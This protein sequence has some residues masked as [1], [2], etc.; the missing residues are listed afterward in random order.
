MGAFLAR[1]LFAS[2]LVMVAVSTL[3]FAL[4][5][6]APGGPSVLADPKLTREEV[7]AIERRLGIDRPLPVQY[8]RWM[9][10]ALRGDLGASFLYRTPVRATIASRL[11]NTALLAG[12]ALLVATLVAV[13]LAL[14]AAEHPGGVADRAAGALSFMALSTPAFWL[15][16]VA[17]LCFA[18]WLR[19]LPAG[20]AATPGLEGSLVDRARHA[21]LP[22]CVLAAGI[23]AEMLRYTRAAAGR[24]Y[25][26][27]W[28]RTARAKGVGEREVR[29]HHVMRHVLVAVLTLIGL[30]LPRLLGG[31]AITETIFAWPGMGR[32]GVEAAL[33]RDYPLIMGI[34][35]AVAAAVVVTNLVVDVMYVCIDP[36]MRGGGAVG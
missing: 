18:V 5:H 20:G 10:S 13:P 15:G 36:R 27:D 32:L 11:P 3:T 19:A 23:G 22:V 25:A 7:A 4:V 2:L 34:T 24:S 16:I 28:V 21:V 9:G 14:R 1:R 29:D 30:Q 26:R 31:A 33:S 35:L 12:L 6:L 17:I 8:A